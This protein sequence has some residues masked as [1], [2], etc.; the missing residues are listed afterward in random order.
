MSIFKKFKRTDSTL[1]PRRLPIDFCPKCGEKM[2]DDFE[3]TKLAHDLEKHPKTKIQKIREYTG[4]H[5][6]AWILIFIAVAVVWSVLTPDV[7]DTQCD[8]LWKEF[9][10]KYDDVTVSLMSMDDI[11]ELDSICKE[12][13]LGTGI[14]LYRI[15]AF[16]LKEF[17]DSLIEDTG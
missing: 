9:S 6:I 2:K 8:I 15:D 12:E 17:L 7:P 4:Q 3:S 16:S 1:K 13:N 14:G 11:L 5:V 10:E